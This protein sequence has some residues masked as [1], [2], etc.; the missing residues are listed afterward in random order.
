MWHRARR[1]HCTR[2]TRSSERMNPRRR[3]RDP[4]RAAPQWGRTGGPKSSSS[5]SGSTM[6][7]SGSASI[8]AASAPTN[9]LASRGRTS[10]RRTRNFSSS[11]GTAETPPSTSYRSLLRRS[12]HKAP[13]TATSCSAGC[14]PHLAATRPKRQSTESR[15]PVI[16]AGVFARLGTSHLRRP[17]PRARASALSEAAASET[18]SSC[19]SRTASRFRRYFWS[20]RRSRPSAGRRTRGKG[21]PWR[22]GN[23]AIHESE[24]LQPGT[25][26]RRGSHRD[27]GP[28]GGA[29]GAPA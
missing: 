14:F 29:L 9:C 11:K 24:G 13:S 17:S 4:R 5:A 21:D 16:S 12:S 23:S 18:R 15:A 19:A 6:K 3:A 10:P 28:R 22:L 8:R 26:C 2:P 27:S 7:W 1:R 20:P 25:S